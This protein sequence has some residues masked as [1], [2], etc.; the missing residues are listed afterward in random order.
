MKLYSINT[1]HFKLD[2]GAM[3]GVVPKSIW[4]RLNPA[5][6]NNI[7]CGT[8]DNKIGM[9]KNGLWQSE[10]GL[11]DVGPVK[12]DPNPVNNGNNAY[13]TSVS[14]FSFFFRRNVNGIW[15]NKSPKDAGTQNANIVHFSKFAINPKN[16]NQIAIGIDRIYETFDKADNW[17]NGAASP[18]FTKDRANAD[19]IAY[20]PDGT[21]WAAYK[22]T[23]WHRDTKNKW[24]YYLT[25]LTNQ[26][27]SIKPDFNTNYIHPKGSDLKYDIYLSTNI[28]IFKFKKNK[29]NPENNFRIFFW[30]IF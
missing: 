17:G 6:E 2:G 27:I 19:A 30:N 10:S 4:N 12:F 18:V 28:N 24:A 14:G 25:N 11:G 9:Y 26:I 5:D 20:A 13:C 7:L 21:L 29:K 3:F 1:G 16:T 22:D 23:L 8:Q 15:E